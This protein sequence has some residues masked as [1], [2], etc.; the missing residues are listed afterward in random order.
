MNTYQVN[1]RLFLLCA[2]MCAA[3]CTASA[4]DTIT[5][6]RPID[7]SGTLRSIEPGK[8]AIVDAQGKTYAC[9]IQEADA[10][11]VSLAGLKFGVKLPPEVKVTGQRALDSLKPGVL[12]QCTAEVNR[13]GNSKGVVTT[14][15]LLDDGAVEPGIKLQGKPASRREHTSAEVTGRL[16]KVRRDRVT[17]DV[18]KSEISR[19]GQITLRVGS[20]MALV[21][22]KNHQRAAAGD[23]VVAAT[24][25]PFS[26]GEY[27]VRSLEILLGSEQAIDSAE[28][29]MLRKYQN[30]S[31]ESTT[32]RD[33][34]SKHFLLHTDISPRSSAILLERLERM[35]E[36]VSR[37]FGRPPDR[38]IE[39][40]VVADLKKWPPDAID[41]AGVAK[42]ASGEG[43]TLSRSLGKQ[44]RSVVYS[45][46]KHGIV[47]HEA[48]HAYC[49]QTFGSTGPT[50][51][52]EGVAEMGNYW[53]QGE[54]AVNINP[55]AI[56]LIQNGQP[57]PLLKIVAPGQ[58]T[59]DSWKAYCWRWALCNMLANNP[60]YSGRF[61]E[62]GI[63]M[64]SGKPVSFE[65]AYG[66]V[67]K[68]ISFEY[69]QFVKHVENGYRSD[70]AA[71]QW[72]RKF[73]PVGSTRPRRVKIRAA[74]GW[75]ASGVSVESGGQYR[76][77]TKGTWTI[78]PGTTVT[79][80]GA[81]GGRGQLQ[82]VVMNDW[83]LS[84]P[85]E[86]GTEATFTA[87]IDG[88]LYLRCRDA[89]NELGDNDG[90]IQASV[91]RAK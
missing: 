79:P 77:E 48:V 31:D 59:G 13:L 76:I 70:L 51:F 35:L 10:K 61:K 17:L 86:L 26:N 49:F 75:Q 45:S 54:L 41:P 30:L 38:L 4:Q 46:K 11:F 68:E 22:S 91:R 44:R 39:C 81:A 18:G 78:G 52:A 6:L 57:E 63:A 3:A 55:V 47:Q 15:K 90:E 34:R 83:K 37:Y 36:L 84:K 19:S 29:A 12:L 71:W 89:W 50:W 60:N 82:G 21:S 23:Q 72:G 14:L 88:N 65:T 87:P 67:A 62:L 53:K 74:A 66:A 73:S 1:K 20:E 58:V 8:L 5:R 56:D 25:I 28:T 43:V 42:I 32:P 40:Y 33:E 9:K 69:L 24:L 64:M 16:A 85:F 2:I 27:V 80:D 7:V